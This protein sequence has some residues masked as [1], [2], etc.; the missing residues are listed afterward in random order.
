MLHHWVSQLNDCYHS[1]NI[2][3]RGMCTLWTSD[4]PIEWT[5]NV[6]SGLGE[7]TLLH[8]LKF[9]FSIISMSLAQIHC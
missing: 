6:P 2:Y 3:Q 5:V 8:T 9:V 7:R 4:L 1:A